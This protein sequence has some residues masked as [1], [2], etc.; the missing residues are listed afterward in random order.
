MPQERCQSQSESL[1]VSLP[2]DNR[3]LLTLNAGD[4]TVGEG[5]NF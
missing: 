5:N 1:N 4:I 2:A 3:Q